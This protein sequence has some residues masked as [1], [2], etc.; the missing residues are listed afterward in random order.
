MLSL[1]TAVLLN[2]SPTCTPAEASSKALPPNFVEAA[3]LV[4][5]VLN[6]I[7]RLD[8][9]A[10]QH[11]LGCSHNRLEFFHLISFLLSYC[12][13]RWP[14]AAPA[15]T[16]A[17]STSCSGQQQGRVE[18]TVSSPKSAAAAWTVVPPAA[19]PVSIESALCS[20]TA[21]DPGSI[22]NAACERSRSSTAAPGIMHHPV[23]KLL[24]QLLLLIGYF[25]VQHPGN[26][27]LLQWGRSPTILQ[28][29]CSVP[30]QYFN[31]PQ[32]EAVLLPTLLSVC[33]EADRLCE[34]VSQHINIGVLLQYV[35]KEQEQQQY[36][37]PLDSQPQQTCEHEIS[38][39]VQAVQQPLQSSQ[40]PV[41]GA[42]STSIGGSRCSR[43]TLGS[44]SLAQY[45]LAKRFPLPAL[46]DA[47]AY[48][49]ARVSS[50]R[51]QADVSS[52]V[53]AATGCS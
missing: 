35:Q 32:L 52:T 30:K 39:H 18:N 40:S 4:M 36:A 9:L 37:L 15:C 2:A 7:C 31:V 53:L 34:L 22:Q 12:S 27:G 50:V 5:S 43:A 14:A 48:I 45:Q 29:L 24:N 17:Q 13:S 26:Q 28:R 3:S 44:S 10:A 1:L 11:M 41:S 21:V 49:Q 38:T 51:R 46:P 42:A 19:H 47:E 16:P 6:N 20:Q 33:F 23:A 8:L 25:S